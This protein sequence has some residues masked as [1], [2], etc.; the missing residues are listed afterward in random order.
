MD[1]PPIPPKPVFLRFDGKDANNNRIAWF[2]CSCG[3]E[4][5]TTAT[6]VNTGRSR[7]CGCYGKA[8]LSAIKT[9]HGESRCHQVVSREYGIWSSI[10]TRCYNTKFRWYHRYGGRG[11]LMCDRW[12]DSYENFISDMGR[13]P[14]DKPTI[15]RR[16][17]NLGYCPDNCVWGTWDEQANNRSNNRPITSD[18]ETRNISAWAKLSGNS[19][20]CIN[21]RLKVGWDMKRAIF[22]KKGTT[23]SWMTIR[24]REAATI[25][26]FT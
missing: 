26:Q 10:K 7:S 8:V 2:R 12:K 6:R 15:E 18:G 22:E 14:I 19:T 1:K 20:Q 9:T 4:W 17:N 5:R 23:T 25:L 13:S 11:I 3:K 21:A 24:A 16:N